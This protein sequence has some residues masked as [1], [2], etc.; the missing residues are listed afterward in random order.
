MKLKSLSKIINPEAVASGF[1]MIKKTIFN[2]KLK[3]KKQASYEKNKNR[4]EMVRD[5]HHHHNF[6]DAT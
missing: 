2:R 5:F 6:V 3:R 4:I 1:F